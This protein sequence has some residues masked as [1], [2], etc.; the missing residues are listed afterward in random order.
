MLLLTTMVIALQAAAPA[1]APASPP[2]ACRLDEAG[3]RANAGLS[4]DDFDQRGTLPSASR[5]LFN[6]G[7]FREAAEATTDYLIRGPVPTP[8]QQRVLL[9]HLGQFL[10][11]A[12]EERRAADF[13][14]ATRRPD[15]PDDPNP[16]RWNDYVLGT[17]AFLVKDRATLIAA[18]DRVLAGEGEGNAMNGGFLAGLERCFDRP[19]RVATSAECR[20]ELRAGG[21]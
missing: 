1:A 13:I 7:C 5:Q 16:L 3:K 4:F 9:F 19:Y 11:H 12:G 21:E 18:R 2:A 8:G 6:A 20:P 17:W 10:A 14:A 15:D